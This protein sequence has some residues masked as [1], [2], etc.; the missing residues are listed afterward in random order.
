MKIRAILTLT[1]FYLIILFTFKKWFIRQLF[2]VVSVNSTNKRS[3]I[4]KTAIAVVC[5]L[6]L[7]FSSLI[8]QSADIKVAR[9]EKTGWWYVLTPIEMR[10]PYHL[11]SSS[12][13]L[14]IKDERERYN[15]IDLVYFSIDKIGGTS[16]YTINGVVDTE[17]IISTVYKKNQAVLIDSAVKAVKHFKRQGF[18]PLQEVIHFYQ[19]AVKESGGNKII[20]FSIE[21]NKND[22]DSRL[23]LI[24]VFLMVVPFFILRA[25]LRKL[26]KYGSGAFFVSLGFLEI[27]SLLMIFFLWDIGWQAQSLHLVWATIA[28]S[29]LLFLGQRFRR[30]TAYHFLSLIPYGLLIWA[31]SV[32]Q[33]K[34]FVITIVATGIIISI[35]TNLKLFYRDKEKNFRKKKEGDNYRE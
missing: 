10:T 25:M 2:L 5:F 34:Y 7:G 19:I 15:L 35:L 28:A 23:F 8:A 3:F 9:A 18:I 21:K 13:R 12:S 24:I 33:E 31:L 30:Y 27:A 22:F 4:M 32:I 20:S 14:V 11:D 16:V 26:E 17:N 29:T 1:W 6:V